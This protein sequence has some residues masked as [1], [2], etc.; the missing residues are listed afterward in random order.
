MTDFA[1][2]IRLLVKHGIEFII[3]GEPLQLRTAPRG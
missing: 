3:I 2:L 1:A